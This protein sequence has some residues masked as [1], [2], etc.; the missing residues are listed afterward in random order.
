MQLATRFEYG[1][2]DAETRIVVQQKTG[3][4]RDRIKR[5][6]SDIM[7]IGERLI[8]I[9]ERL[10]HGRFAEWLQIEFEWSDRTARSLMSVAEAFK[11]ANFSDLNIAPS[12][13]YVLAAPSVP[14]EARQQAVALASNGH[15]VTH[16]E[17]KAIIAEHKPAPSPGPTA[18]SPD[19]PSASRAS[20]VV[21]EQDEDEEEED[22]E[23]F[24]LEEEPHPDEKLMDRFL[25][26]LLN[27]SI[28]INRRGGVVAVA[29]NCH[30]Q[31]AVAAIERLRDLRKLADQFI[32]ELREARL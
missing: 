9:K 32:S 5:T 24:D 25:S 30:P 26:E 13:M 22:D 19:R 6:A 18:R 15:H 7:E 4:I 21:D 1:T 20:V 23:P 17:A 2:L 11:S 16:S 8:D 27:F 28:T 31:K 12:A 29:G 14:E 10:G 3:E